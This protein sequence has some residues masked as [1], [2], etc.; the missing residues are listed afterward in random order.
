MSNEV[1]EFVS[2]QRIAI[3]WEDD[4]KQKQ[5]NKKCDSNGILVSE[6]SLHSNPSTI[7]ISVP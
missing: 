6:Q 2:F 1:L 5:N 7:S 4:E 3:R